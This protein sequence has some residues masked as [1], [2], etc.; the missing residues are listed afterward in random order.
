MQKF[1]VIVKNEIL[2]NSRH[3]MTLDQIKEFNICAYRLAIKSAE[4]GGQE[5][6][7]GMWTVKREDN[8]IHNES[9][10]SDFLLSSTVTVCDACFQVSCWQGEFMCDDAKTAG[11]V[12]KTVEELLALEHPHYW[13]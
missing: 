8:H 3:E 12:E 5:Y 9:K 1:I 13:S 10:L 6:T 7:D 2:G 11:T 4:N